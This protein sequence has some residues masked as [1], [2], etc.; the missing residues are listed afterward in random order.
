M[1]LYISGR[2]EIFFTEQVFKT[3]RKCSA[4]FDDRWVFIILIKKIQGFKDY[5]H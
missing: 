4:L 3:Q 5:L 2:T 1:F